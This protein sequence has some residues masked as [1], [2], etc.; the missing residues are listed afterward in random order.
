MG[1]EINDMRSLKLNQMV[2]EKIRHQPGLIDFV[3]NNLQR[4][5]S[6]PVLSDS[7]KEALSEWD[8]L[9]RFQPLDE[10]LNLLVENSEKGQQLRQSSPFWGV[11]TQEERRS[12]FRQYESAR[13]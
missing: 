3:R 13:A 5:L 4:A 6:D 10:V 2:V 1:H 8:Q 12:V 7:C 11:L 9:F